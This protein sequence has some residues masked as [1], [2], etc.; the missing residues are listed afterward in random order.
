MLLEKACRTGDSRVDIAIGFKAD[1]D[2]V[3]P[4]VVLTETLNFGEVR[5]GLRHIFRDR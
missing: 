5:L 1:V 3:P 2:D 4:R